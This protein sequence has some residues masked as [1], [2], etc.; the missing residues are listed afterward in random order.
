VPIDAANDLPAVAFRPAQRQRQTGDQR[1]NG[2]P[3]FTRFGDAGLRSRCVLSL[4][5]AAL[6]ILLDRRTGH[7]GIGTE[8]AAIAG[9]GLQLHAAAEAVV[10][11]DAGVGGHGLGRDMA[12][13]RTGQ[14]GLE[15]GRAPSFDGRQ[16]RQEPGLDKGLPGERKHDQQRGDDKQPEG[17]R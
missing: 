4:A 2:T 15:Q 9:Q 13:M 8:D 5:A 1:R 16:L 12:A 14:R 11:P 3:A 17:Q 6:A 7:V 10:E